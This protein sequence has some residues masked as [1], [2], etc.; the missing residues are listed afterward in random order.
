MTTRPT[1]II[2]SGFTLVIFM[3]L[4]LLVVSLY[5]LSI[6]KHALEDEIQVESQHASIATSL[7]KI[8]DN[9]SA[10]LL[11]I[12]KS[13][14]SFDQEEM[15]QE[16]YHLGGNFIQLRE[17]LIS[18]R[19]SNYEGNLISK[20]TINAGE[21]GP[22]QRQVIQYTLEDNHIKAQTLFIN[23]ALPKQ[24]VS[25]EYLNLL[26]QYQ[27][28]EINTLI[29]SLISRENNT[30]LIILTGSI[31]LIFFCIIIA[32]F[33]YRKLTLN[34]TEIQQAHDDLQF[35]L[36]EVQNLKYAIDLHAIVSI[37]DTKG[38]ITYVNDKFCHTSQYSDTE[39][40]GQYHNI[41]NSGLHSDT[42]F[43]DLWT[44]IQ[45][46]AAWHGE[47]R[48]RKKD[49]THY[50]VEST[51]VPFLDNNNTPYQYIAIR[52]DITHIK[53]IEE[54]LQISF[55]QLAAEAEKAQEAS[56]LKDSIM[57]TMTHE[58]RT[59]LNSIL[60]FSQ[61][62]LLEDSNFTDIQIS[63]L[64]S[65]LDSGNELLD[66]IE[67]IML[68]SNLKSKT[69]KI[70]YNESELSTII[71]SVIN[72]A[73]TLSSDTNIIPTLKNT[74]EHFIYTDI[75]LLQKSLYYI[76]DNAVKFTIKGHITIQ[77]K[78][79]SKN[80]KIPEQSKPAATD[81]IL[82]TIQDTGVGI[83]EEKIKF[84]FDEFR[85]AD[86]KDNRQFEGFGIGL[87]LAKSIINHL[88]GELWLI[89]QEGIG[90]T[91]Y[92]SIPNIKR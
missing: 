46:G 39:L 62:L 42:F 15:V 65:I 73:T 20:L 40:I 13:T 90:T 41:I 12:L 70:Q 34:V 48:N 67:S 35:S 23:Q 25:A 80:S 72:R 11:K 19:L 43:R 5:Q 61:L 57:S 1:T 59:P 31:M 27:H 75:T 3:I 54:D 74:Q 17:T 78:E 22:I 88:N 58:L 2:L 71:N 18:T 76:I 92:I 89:S 79:I 50:W 55:E 81:I 64:Q 38:N 47:I 69:M 26:S 7:Q 83:N 44:T 30:Y 63:S 33:I 37:T 45:S 28:E 68:Y 77:F 53:N 10:L 14:D 66:K 36:N 86:E 85:Q 91:V 29:A 8:S 82:I 32:L 52:T 87:T 4:A 21:V 24:Q 51:V 16:F 6:T 84:I 60:G 56:T 9:R 49:G